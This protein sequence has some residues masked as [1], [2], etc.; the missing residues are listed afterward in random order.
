M[1]MYS[2]CIFMYTYMLYL[3][4]LFSI[5][6]CTCTYTLHVGIV[7]NQLEGDDLEYTLRLRHE[8]GVENSWQ[9]REA[10]SD[11]QPPGPRV[12]E[13][14]VWPFHMGLCSHLLQVNSSYIYMYTQ[15]SCPEFAPYFFWHSTLVFFM[16]ICTCACMY[17]Y[18]YT[19]TCSCK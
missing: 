10:A 18:V 4:V 8:V 17:M 7:F 9:T 5:R 6:T 11:L 14:S 3:H 13:K 12:S 1:Y 19:C 16:Y 2:T 15:N